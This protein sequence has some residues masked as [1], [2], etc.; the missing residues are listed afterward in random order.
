IRIGAPIAPPPTAAR[1]GL[2]AITAQCATEIHRL[3]DLG[4]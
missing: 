1:E 3:H 4:R 2:E